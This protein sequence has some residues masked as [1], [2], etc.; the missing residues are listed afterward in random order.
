MILARLEALD[1][2]D[3][4]EL[5]CFELEGDSYPAVASASVGLAG[6]VGQERVVAMSM[7]TGVL[8][9]MEV[10]SDLPARHARL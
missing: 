8:Q 5:P 7:L 10:S 3:T 2:S 4:L 1:D 6:I 9:T